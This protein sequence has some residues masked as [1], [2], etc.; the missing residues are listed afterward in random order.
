MSNKHKFAVV[1]G[2]KGTAAVEFA[3][4]LPIL[5]LLIIGIFDYADAVNISTKLYSSARAGVQ[6]GLYHPGDLTGVQGV[7]NAS[8]LQTNEGGTSYG[9]AAGAATTNYYCYNTSTGVIDFTA[10]TSTYDCTNQVGASWVLGHFLALNPTTSPSTYGT[11]YSFRGLGGS[12]SLT[13]KAIIQV[14]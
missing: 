14:Q 8:T 3:V 13:G 10:R 1:V 5:M 2:D 11:L 9:M 6:Y 12:L 4:T 7:A